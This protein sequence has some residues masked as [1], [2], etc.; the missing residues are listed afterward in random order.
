MFDTVPNDILVTKLEK[1]G[2]GVW[3]TCCI[4]NWLD[5]STQRV[6]VNSSMSKWRS[7]MHGIPHGSVLGL[8]LFNIFVG[9]MDSGIKVTRSRFA[10]DTKLSG[11]DDMLEE[12]DA[13]QRDLDL[14]WEMGPRQPHE[15]Q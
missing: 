10:D 1:N 15:A 14:A 4:R 11:A 9:D 13:I 12:R 5:G 8:V 7:E 3:T 2:F 6:A